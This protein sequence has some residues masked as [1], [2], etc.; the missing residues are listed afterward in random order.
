MAKS[1]TIAPGMVMYREDV[2]AVDVIANVLQGAGVNCGHYR[3]VHINVIPESA[4]IPTVAVYWWSDK[5]GKFIQEHT[6][7]SKG[8]LAANIPFGFTV[9]A[10]GRIM[11]V[12]VAVLATGKV[13]IELAGYDLDHSL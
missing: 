5:A 10:R 4:A 2:A 8:G 6:A 1:L 9:E 3:T 12:A 13:S 7:I 11:F